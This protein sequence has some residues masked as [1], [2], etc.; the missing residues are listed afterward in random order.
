MLLTSK[1]KTVIEFFHYGFFNVRQQHSVKIENLG[2]LKIPI[3]ENCCP[4]EEI[5]H[6]CKSMHDVPNVQAPDVLLVKILN[7]TSCWNIISMLDSTITKVEKRHNR[8]LNNGFVPTA[9][10]KLVI[11]Q[12]RRIM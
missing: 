6:W 8:R 2:K 5:Q 11:K 10:S 9:L 12:T 1:P 3:A 4:L 7:N